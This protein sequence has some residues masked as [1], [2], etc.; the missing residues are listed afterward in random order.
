MRIVGGRY[1]GREIDAPDGRDTRP[2]SDRAREGLFNILEHG[3]PGFRLPDA[4]IADIFAG[5]GAL[6]LEALSRG[7][8][9]VV[10]VESSAA[11]QRVIAANIKGLTD[12]DQ[13]KAKLQ[14]TSAEA[15][16]PAASPVDLVL[17]DPPYGSGL[18]V[19][20]L[21]RLQAQ[22]WL[23]GDSIIVIEDAEDAADAEHPGFELLKSRRY[24]KALFSFL[25]PA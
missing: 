6:G 20:A 24:G 10:F 8:A 21:Q 4:A 16:R 13:A 14:R 7:A 23:H 12:E 18:A 11:A 25:K 2:T 5:S 15:L 1:R 9:S 17:M 22:G 19:K 3:I